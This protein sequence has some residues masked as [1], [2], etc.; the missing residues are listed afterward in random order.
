MVNRISNVDIAKISSDEVFFVDTN[1]LLAIHFNLSNWD[2][3]KTSVYSSF[4]F[5][6]LSKGNKLCVSMLNLQELYNLV[7]RLEY[8]QYI[9]ADGQ[10]SRKKYRKIATER[11]RIAKD[12]QTKHL[13]LSSYYDLIQCT[14]KEECMN[15]FIDNY[16]SHVY[17]PID[18][19]TV[20]YNT[21]NCRNFITDDSD[22]KCD[23][24]LNVYS[25]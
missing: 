23:P 2:M 17:E 11:E 12:L 3:T 13:E 1:V 25:Y 16:K 15:N 10:I 5:S 18:F 9:L 19:I 8:E 24:N 22:F 21:N 4:V 7:E 14:I 6:L 20:R